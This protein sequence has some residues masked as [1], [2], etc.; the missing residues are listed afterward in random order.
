MRKIKSKIISALNFLRYLIMSRHWRGHGVHSPFVYDFVRNVLFDRTIYP[1]YDFFK[2]I[3]SS[4]KDSSKSIQVDDLGDDSLKFNRKNRKV[5]D[6]SKISSISPKFGELLFRIAS[7]YKPETIIELGT[8]IGVS[9]IYL[10]KG[11]PQ[12]KILTVEGNKGLCD[13]A[14]SLFHKNNLKKI[15]ILH[16][17]FDRIVES[18]PEGFSSPELVFIDGNHTYESTFRYYKFFKER[19][20]EGILIIDDINWSAGM[21]KVWKDIV[22]QNDE[23]VTIDLFRLG[24]I[25]IRKSITAGNYIVRF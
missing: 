17:D 19:M 1:E 11:N 21:C 7:Y 23:F 10:S 14:A 4:L 6:L 16:A 22:N 3:I 20:M 8:S 24:I 12:A 9:S 2:T 25:I 15:T 18:L 13:F 5:S